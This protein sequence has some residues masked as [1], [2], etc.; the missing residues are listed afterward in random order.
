MEYSTVQTENSP[1]LRIKRVYDTPSDEDGTRILVD[2]LWPRGMKRDAGVVDLWL[3]DVAPTPSLRR[4]FSHDPSRW[5]EFVR[6]YFAELDQRRQTLAPLL[7]LATQDCIT[8]LYA[9]KDERRNNA[10]ALARYLVR[11]NAVTPDGAT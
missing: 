2:R 8:L 5:S 10:V 6:R 4:W 7:E 3:K 9:A 1:C 11:C